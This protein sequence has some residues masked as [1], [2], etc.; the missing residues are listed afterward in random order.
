MTNERVW[1]RIRAGCRVGLRCLG[2]LALVL[3]LTAATCTSGAGIY[4]K[5]T[6]A[7]L[8]Q[9]AARSALQAYRTETT[10]S[11]GD[12]VTIP[13][14]EGAVDG[15]L[16]AA[17]TDME[18]LVREPWDT[19][20]GYFGPTPDQD[21]NDIGGDMAMD[22]TTVELVAD[23]STLYL[24]SP[25]Y[26]HLHDLKHSGNDS[27]P[28][29]RILRLGEEWGRIDLASTGLRPVDVSRTLTGYPNPDPRELLR[30]LSDVGGVEELGGKTVRGQPLGGLTAEVRIADLLEVLGTQPARLMDGASGGYTQD[31]V[32]RTLALTVPV[33]VWINDDRLVHQVSFEL[34]TDDIA[35][36]TG[37]DRALLADRLKSAGIVD[38]DSAYTVDYFDYNESVN[39]EVPDPTFELSETDMT[40]P[41]SA[42]G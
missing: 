19:L 14:A 38:V 24:R 23:C 10:V 18:R 42:A 35:D 3:S 4:V 39:I 9:M 30:L 8:A 12:T 22:D 17:T 21:T 26:A 7:S 16:F 36:Q 32:R 20:G 31:L 6:P 41:A 33:E 1:G 28:N 37:E 34:K 2:G 11:F 13:L 25:F 5:A 29:K 27:D 40:M 15:D